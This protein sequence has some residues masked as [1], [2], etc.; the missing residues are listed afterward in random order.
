MPR[1]IN[2]TNFIRIPIRSAVKVS[3][4]SNDWGENLAYS[5]ISCP[6][7]YKGTWKK[8]ENITLSIPASNSTPINEGRKQLQK[9][10]RGTNIQGITGQIS[11][12]GS[13]RSQPTN[14]LVRPKCTDTK[15]TGFEPA[16]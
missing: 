11:F 8:Y 9:I 7:I 15:Y 10:V 6:S 3:K 4:K 12:K 13:D 1:R 16:F 5:Q 2:F 14:I